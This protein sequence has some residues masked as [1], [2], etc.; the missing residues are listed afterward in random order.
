MEMTKPTISNPQMNVEDKEEIDLGEILSTLWRGKLI[1]LAF[2]IFALLVGGYYAF[3]SATPVY[4]ARSTVA[5]ES[6]KEQVVDIESVMTGLGGDQATIN[7]E[8]EV[9]QSRKLIGDLV[10]DMNL[11]A[12]PEFNASLREQPKYSVRKAIGWV[13]GVIKGPSSP[14]QPKDPAR[15]RDA[16]VSSVSSAISI[17]NIRQSYVFQITA[18]TQDPRKSAMIANRL[19]DLYIQDQISVKFERTEKATEWLSER[20]SELRI[21]LEETETSL[22]AFSSGA[23]LISPEG[24]FALNR[25][26]KELR[27]KRD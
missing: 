5:L 19:A 4:T 7:T 10:D 21:H 23:D 6:R 1:I 9:M 13:V 24:L 16:V 3:I 22:K 14:A 2:A 17:S 12:D 25:Q 8:V 11:I 20:V 27:E 26:L 18:I 15:V